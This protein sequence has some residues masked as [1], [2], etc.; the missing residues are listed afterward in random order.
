MKGVWRLPRGPRMLQTNASNPPTTH[1]RPFWTPL[2]MSERRLVPAAARI[3]R[4]V[5]ARAVYQRF[6]QRKSHAMSAE[7]PNCSWRTWK[8]VGS[9]AACW[10]SPC[11]GTEGELEAAQLQQ[12]DRQRDREPDR[13]PRP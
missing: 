10:D 1:S 7:S 12:E 6:C 11:M 2:G 4:A 9:S 13:E 5:M 3:R 8:R